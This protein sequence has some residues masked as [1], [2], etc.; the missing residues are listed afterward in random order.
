MYLIQGIDLCLA[1][2]GPIGC[3]ALLIDAY[4][5][6]AGLTP[7]DDPAAIGQACYGWPGISATCHSV[8][9]SFSSYLG[10]ASF[11][12][13]LINPTGRCPSYNPSAILQVGNGGV[14]LAFI[15]RS[16]Y[17]DLAGRGDGIHD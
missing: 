9:E 17:A 10:A 13:L 5:A 1:K 16:I 12:A 8:D 6:S 15:C 3:V 2:R 14:I 7:S 11:I 4:G